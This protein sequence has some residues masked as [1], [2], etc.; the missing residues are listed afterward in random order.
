M[1]SVN[2]FLMM[3]ISDWMYILYIIKAYYEATLW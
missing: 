2:E 3:K 1:K